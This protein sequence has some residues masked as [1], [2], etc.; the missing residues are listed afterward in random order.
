VIHGFTGREAVVSGPEPAPGYYGQPVIHRP[1]WQWLI[2]TYFFLGGISGSAAVIGSLARLTGGANATRTSQI[3]T[4]VSFL[5]LLPCPVCLI[6]DL[7]RPTRFLNMVKTFRPSSPM[8]VGTWGFAAFGLIN[9]LSV[10]FQALA[11]YQRTHEVEDARPFLGLRVVA[12][13]S[14]LAGFFVAGYTGVLLAATAVPLWSKQ[15]YIIAPLFLASAMSSGSA[16]VVATI[17]IL[18]PEGGVSD[19]RLNNFEAVAAITEASL[20][21]VW[22][23][24]LGPTAKPLLHGRLGAVVRHGAVGAGIVAPMVI[25]ALSQRA[26]RGR[27]RTMMIVAS[28]LSLAGVFAVRFAVVEGGRASADDPVATFEMTK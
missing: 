8:S 18:D 6:L 10:L 23:V 28:L 7:G 19:H 24:A 2:T 27:R 22:L 11:D 5:A 13:P 14:A 17:A 1:H 21:A 9:T 20:L 26:P 25:T 16:A 4:Y 15:P 12:V 3:A